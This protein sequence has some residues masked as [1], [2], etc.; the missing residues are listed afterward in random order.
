MEPARLFLGRFDEDTLRAELMR[1]G[2]LDVLADRGYGDVVLQTRFA[3]GQHQ[4]RVRPRGRRVLLIDLRLGEGGFTVH[5]SGVEGDSVKILS[6]LSV[7]WL[8]LQDPGRPF[9]AQRPRLPGQRYP[10]LGLGKSIHRLVLRWADEW[11]KDALFNLPE[12]YHNAV[13]YS[14][15][16]RFVDAS[17]AGRFEALKRDLRTLAVA[18]ASWAIHRGEVRE[19]S[20]DTA[21]VWQGT[22][23]MAPL[24]DDAKGLVE[25]PAYA[26]AADEMVRSVSYVIEPST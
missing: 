26:Q 24:T 5:P 25:S 1:A 14:S 6:V 7:N 12:H 21:F 20:K 22:E 18:D 4:L 19:R 10:G 17:M 8:A 11:G 3:Q 15:L 9:T 23:M 2:A 13:F 16:Y